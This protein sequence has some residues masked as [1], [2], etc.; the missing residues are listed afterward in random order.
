MEHDDFSRSIIIDEQTKQ[1]QLVDELLSSNI[2]FKVDSEGVWYNMRDSQLVK[3][4]TYKI[5]ADS[6]S[7][8]STSFSYP[9]PKYTDILINKLHENNIPYLIEVI[10]S[11]KNIVL[12]NHDLEQWKPHKE[13]VDEMYAQ[14]VQD[15]INSSE[16]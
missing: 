5:M 14:Q 6:S 3:D 8:N 16:E 9:D 15:V 4:I 7:Y 12:Q 11:K 2:P 10:D 13:I 1:Q